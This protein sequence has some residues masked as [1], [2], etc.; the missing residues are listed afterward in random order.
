MPTN[1]VKY[2]RENCVLY[3]RQTRTCK[4]IFPYQYHTF[5]F[6]WCAI[7]MHFH[8]QVALVVDS[9]IKRRDFKAHRLNASPESK[10]FCL[11]AST[12]VG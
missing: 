8:E 6:F 9:L 10:L 12:Q 4:L 2:A 1:F 3:A 5:F 11:C 7:Y